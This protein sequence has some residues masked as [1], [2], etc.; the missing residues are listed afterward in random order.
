MWM[1]LAEGPLKIIKSQS[2]IINNH[3]KSSRNHSEEQ[4]QISQETL[5]NMKQYGIE[6]DLMVLDGTGKILK[7]K[8]RVGLTMNALDWV[9]VT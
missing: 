7:V 3:F 2:E 4:V 8:K 1:D 5:T 6:W 9:L